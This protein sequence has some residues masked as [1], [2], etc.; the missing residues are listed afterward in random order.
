MQVTGLVQR[1]AG[2]A[3]T[4]GVIVDPLAVPEEAISINDSVR[5]R[6]MML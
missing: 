3:A 2:C 5:R 1:A 4:R 6:W